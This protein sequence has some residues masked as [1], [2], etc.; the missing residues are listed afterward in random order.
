[1][2]LADISRR[3]STAV[4]RLEFAAPINYVYNPLDYARQPHEEYL[5]RFGHGPKEVLLIGMNPGPFGMAQTGVPFGD[6][7][8]VRDWMEFRAPV[9]KPEREHPKRPVTGFDC[10]RREVSGTR[11]WGWARDRFGTPEIFFARFFVWNYCP[12]CFVEASGKNFTPDKLPAREKAALFAACDDALCGVVETLQPKFV[13][14]VGGFAEERIR[15]ALDEDKYTI[16]RILHPSPA[17]PAANR[18]WAGMVEREFKAM[19]IALD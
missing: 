18:D 9:G 12:L 7:A 16:G 11:L 1:M 5:R 14:G 10:A 19:G 3:L 8:M 4:D 6:V 15:A 17:S 13:I 2:S